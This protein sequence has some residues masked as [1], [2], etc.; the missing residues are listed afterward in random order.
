MDVETLGNPDQQQPGAREDDFVDG[1]DEGRF[2]QGMDA[3]SEHV[4][5]PGSSDERVRAGPGVRHPDDDH[6]ACG[7]GE[8]HTQASARS[9]YDSRSEGLSA[10]EVERL[11][12]HCDS[13]LDAERFPRRIR[14]N[15][16]S[17]CGAST[18]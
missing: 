14:P 8:A 6:A 15:A 7:V 5:A 1:D 10:F 17:I 13:R 2:G 4:D 3:A 16:F 9:W 11:R 18:F 12:L